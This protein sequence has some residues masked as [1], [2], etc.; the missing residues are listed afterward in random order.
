MIEIK[1]K[2]EYIEKNIID[3]RNNVLSTNYTDNR[4][5]TLVGTIQVVGTKIELRTKPN[6]FL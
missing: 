2:S 5:N 3:C 1:K 6:Q 4:N